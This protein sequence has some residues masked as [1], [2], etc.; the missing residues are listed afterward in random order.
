[1]FSGAKL[2][3]GSETVRNFRAVKFLFRQID[4]P[5]FTSITNLGHFFLQSFSTTRARQRKIQHFDFI[6]SMGSSP[7]LAPQHAM[8]GGKASSKNLPWQLLWPYLKVFH[9]PEWA[10]QSNFD[11]VP[12]VLSN[13]SNLINGFDQN[14][15]T[16]KFAFANASKFPKW[17]PLILKTSLPRCSNSD[18]F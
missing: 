8:D 9:F 14:L 17:R 16:T 18:K 15:N 12:A 1:M 2:A 4:I 6:Q 3:K 5:D 7:A 13:D 10:R 11:H